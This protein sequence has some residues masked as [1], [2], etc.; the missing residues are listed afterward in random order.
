MEDFAIAGQGHRARLVHGLANFLA[1]DLAR[2]GAEADAAVA[3]HPAY[4]RARNAD[5][6]MLDWN[7]GHIFRML[8]CFLNAA[9]GLVE[10]GNHA[11]AQAPRFAEAVPTVTQSV[12]AQSSPRT[13]HS[14]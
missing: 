1:G 4:M 3:I 12:L 7:T 13:S 2:S 14:T 8:H 9:D 11:L 10:F 6:R 5:Q